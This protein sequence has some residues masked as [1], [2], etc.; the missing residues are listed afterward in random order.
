M[1]SESLPS[2][3]GSTSTLVRGMELASLPLPELLQLKQEPEDDEEKELRREMQACG[4][5]KPVYS[6]VHTHNIT[7]Q[8]HIKCIYM[9][10][11]VHLYMYRQCLNTHLT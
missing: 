4:C 5:L 10:T 11:R 9:C 3:L 7:V 8:K 6:N 1:S 2:K